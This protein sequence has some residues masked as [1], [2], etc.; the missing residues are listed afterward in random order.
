MTYNLI[1]TKFFTII[2]IAGILLFSGCTGKDTGDQGTDIENAPP[3]STNDLTPE[4]PDPGTVQAVHFSKLIELLPE[5]PAGWTAQ[6]P[7]GNSFTIE[8]GSWSMASRA[9]TKDDAGSATVTI[10]DSAYY[11]VGLFQ[12]WSGFVQWESTDGYYKTTTVKGFPA[13]ETY[14]KSGKTYG[15]YINIKDRFMVYIIAE[16]ND[17]DVLNALENS[18]N[19]N[20]IGKLG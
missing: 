14:S 7:Q 18:I 20:G 12:A 15:R 3:S 2:A 5:S 11:N 16:N 13:F 4:K 9:Y 1:D 17:K 19:F 6:E 10:M 8:E